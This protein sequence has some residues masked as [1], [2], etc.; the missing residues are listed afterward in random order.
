MP[1]RPLVILVLA[2]TVSCSG[3]ADGPPASATGSSPDPTPSTPPALPSASP[4][5]ATAAVEVPPPGGDPATACAR[6]RPCCAAFVAAIGDETEAERARIAC[7]QMDHVEE[8]GPASGDACLAAIDGWRRALELSERE[9][10]GAC[11]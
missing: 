5:G 1:L 11:L 4:E 3:E 2:L 8:L 9:I 6:A 7:E 10:P